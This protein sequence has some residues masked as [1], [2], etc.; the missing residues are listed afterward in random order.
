MYPDSVKIFGLSKVLIQ[1]RSTL[2]LK[3]HISTQPAITC[4][5][6]TIEQGAIYAES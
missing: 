6:L 5:K 2:S 1:L 4:L 3:L